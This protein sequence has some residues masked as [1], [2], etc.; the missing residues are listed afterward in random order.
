MLDFIV[1][2]L[3]YYVTPV[4]LA[5]YFFV[6]NKFSFFKDRNIPSNSHSF[7]NIL[8]DLTGA[9]TKKHFNKC[10]DDV[11]EKF[12]KEGVVAGFYQLLTPHYLITDLDLVKAVLIKDFHVFTDRGVY[13]N[14]EDDPLSAHL[15]SIEGERWKFLRTKLSPTFTS[16][17]IKM[18]YSTITEKGQ[19]LIEVL[20]KSMKNGPIEMK[21]I[22]V[23]FT[24]DVISS[25][26]FGL[27]NHAMRDKDSEIQKMAAEV[28]TAKGLRILYFFFCE[29]FK[30]F[31]RKMHLKM[32]PAKVSDF[33]MNI[34]RSTITYRETNNVQRPDFLN[35]L[36]QL[37]NKGSIEGE[38]KTG[39]SRK[40]TFNE[41]AAQAFVFFFA[42]DYC[43]KNVFYHKTAINND[44]FIGFETSSTAMTF[45]LYE[46]ASNQEVQDKVRDE[47]TSVIKAHDG[48]I[49][50]EA[51]NE[52]PYLS[53]V[54]NE[55][56]RKHPPVGALQ[57]IANQEYTFP[58]TSHTIR[59]GQQIIIPV[60][61][62]QHDADI[63]PNPDTFDPD[64][65][66]PEN[67]EARHNAAFLPFGEGFF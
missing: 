65:F 60:T 13:F 62:I 32:F 11:Y 64:R 56:L 57:R 7:P 53:M 20:E 59:K 67:V 51:L 14:E 10:I 25:C 33:F 4:V 1:K 5:L 63:Y 15:F 61:G 18:M 29:N 16:G 30:S 52:M 6:N 40:F 8:G 43:I 58:G 19:E 26:A 17:K 55:T 23:R 27:E 36:M 50:Y 22:S 46:I 45:A 31:S 24:I 42:G 9:G 44:I 41:V 38:E 35:L 54:F 28:F 47:I 12:K 39:D 21:D 66:L 48:K 37:K 34:I 3:L 2:A 49:T